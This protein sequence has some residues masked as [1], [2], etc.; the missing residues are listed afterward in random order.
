[1]KILVIDDDDGFRRLVA[2]MLTTE[3]HEVIAASDGV[4]GMRLFRE[5]KPGVVITDI[6]MPNQEGIETI[7]QLRREN[8]TIRIIAMSGSLEPSGNA[9]FL[10]MAQ[11][12][13]ADETIAKPFR[14]RELRAVVRRLDDHQNRGLG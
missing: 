2:K 1:M 3:G 13:G 4:E 6:I 12:L 8:P 11:Q 7:L 10:K 14:A 9:G 5:E